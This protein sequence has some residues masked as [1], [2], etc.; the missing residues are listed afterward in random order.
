MTTATIGLDGLAERLDA[1]FGSLGA[2]EKRA[3]L[4]IYRLLAR[5]IPVSNSVLADELEMTTEKLADLILEWPGVHRNDKG[6][7][8]GFGGLAIS[9]MPH[10]FQ[11]G[12]RQLY[13]WCAWDG[14]FLPEILGEPAVITS[15]CPVT[16]AEIH[17]QISP[18]GVEEVSPVSTV[19]SLVDPANAEIES[20]RIISS[21]CH[22]IHFFASREVG[23]QW[24]AEKGDGAFVLTLAEAFELGRLTN[25]LRY[26]DALLAPSH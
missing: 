19:V 20:D 11:L 23:D 2:V 15:K 3:A 13:T 9:E 1:S 17:L 18:D 10:R 25:A 21:F 6:D 12:V 24:V 5:G 14:L 16:A 26:G 4:A 8:V 22:H 7:I